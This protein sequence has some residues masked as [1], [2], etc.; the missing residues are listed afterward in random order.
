MPSLPPPEITRSPAASGPGRVN[1]PAFPPWRLWMAPAAVLLGLALGQVG[2]IIV[3]AI[4]QAAGGSSFTHPS[5]AVSIIGDVVA[6]LAFVAA[7]IY[8]AAIQRHARPRDF[9]F[10]RTRA[11]RAVGLGLG[12]G[13]QLLPADLGLCRDL[14]PPRQGQAP[15]R[16]RCKPQHRGAGRCRRIRVRDR[17][18]GGGVLLPWIPVRCAAPLADRRLRARRRHR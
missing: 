14:Q 15:E 7:A 8:L 16:A 17:A 12:R 11:S 10:R 2:V 18:D 5:P 6:D 4:G 3:N 1:E 13:G 9:G